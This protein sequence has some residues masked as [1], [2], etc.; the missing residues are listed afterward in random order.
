MARKKV[1]EKRRIMHY[2]KK[3]PNPKAYSKTTG[4][5]AIAVMRNGR[6]GEGPTVKSVIKHFRLKERHS[7]IITRNQDDIVKKLNLASPF[8][9]WGH[10]SFKTMFNLVHK[11]ATFRPKNSFE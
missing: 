8:L 7:L 10:I 1:E 9:I 11:K 5:N 2:L 6:R 4:Y 3:T